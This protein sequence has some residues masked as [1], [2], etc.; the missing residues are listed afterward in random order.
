MIWVLVVLIRLLRADA[1]NRGIRFLS[2]VDE[3]SFHDLNLLLGE[4]SLECLQLASFLL[5]WKR[6][7]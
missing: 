6:V 2:Y 4:V 1:P 7:D 3:V 5:R